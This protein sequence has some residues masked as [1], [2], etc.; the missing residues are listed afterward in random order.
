MPLLR[1]TTADKFI[2]DRRKPHRNSDVSRAVRRTRDRLSQQAGNPAFDRELLKLHA[3]AIINSATAIPLLVLTI[4]AAGILAGMSMDILTWALVTVTCYAGL[5]FV[6]LSVEKS[7]AADLDVASTTAFYLGGHL[8]S[9]VGWSYFALLACDECGGGQ[10]PV[11][12]AVVLLLAI[13]ATALVG[14]ALRG[15]LIATFDLPVAVYALAGAT[16][17]LPAEAVL[18]GL[19]M[20][21]LTF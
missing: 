3:Q 17:S 12:K 18:A 16:L 7:D 19:L 11:I 9:G 21:S 5:A 13:A 8:L 2:V 14:S 15:A 4:A 10:F 1:S 20:H 6:A